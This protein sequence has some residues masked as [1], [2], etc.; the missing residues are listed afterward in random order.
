MFAQ[1]TLHIY[2]NHFAGDYYFT[3]SQ[4]NAHQSVNQFKESLTVVGNDMCV[5]FGFRVK[6]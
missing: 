5:C 6:K 4:I 3:E 1:T 2:L